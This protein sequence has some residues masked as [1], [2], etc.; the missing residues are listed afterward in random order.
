MNEQDNHVE[1][2]TSTPDLVVKQVEV[3]AVQHYQA[4][5]FER[6]RDLLSK[7]LQ[8]RPQ[9]VEY[10][11]LLGVCYR[12]Q[13]KRAAALKCFKEAVERDPE[14]RNALINLAETLCEVGKATEGVTLMRA[15][16]EEGYDPDK[17]PNEQDTITK[18][19][20]AQLAMIARAAEEAIATERARTP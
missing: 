19:A 20:G 16:F 11:T 2:L 15:V 5:R 9:N 3:A 8:M 17:N 7:L 12:R 10:W 14:Y 13:G 4:E 1:D 18:R 6:A